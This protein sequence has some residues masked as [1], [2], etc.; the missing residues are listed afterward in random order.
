MQI[1]MSDF[2]CARRRY[3]LKKYTFTRNKFVNETCWSTGWWMVSKN[4]KMVMW[5]CLCIYFILREASC[6]NGFLWV[7]W[8]EV[9]LRCEVSF[10]DVWITI[11]ITI[12]PDFLTPLTKASSWT[13]QMWRIHNGTFLIRQVYI[14]SSLY[15]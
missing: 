6:K 14:L 12:T 2:L 8:A 9:G 1:L 7:I 13:E 5:M 3:T 15:T 11:F 4:V 10:S